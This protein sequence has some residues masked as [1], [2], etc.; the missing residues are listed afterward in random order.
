MLLLLLLI[1]T[2]G[3]ANAIANIGDMRTQRYVVAAVVDP[4]DVDSS[5]HDNMD[6]ANVH[7]ND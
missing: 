7:D 6:A 1:L 4:N 2:G 5:N 3:G